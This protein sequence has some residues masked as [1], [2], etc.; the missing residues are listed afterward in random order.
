MYT[1]IGPSSCCII[2]CL[3]NSA[4]NW[5]LLSGCLPYTFRN[6]LCNI[7]L[8]V[9]K[10]KIALTVMFLNCHCYAS[11]TRFTELI[12]HRLIEKGV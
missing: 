7:I 10:R 5:W 6:V 8:N 12:L 11:A 2:Q 9:S 4:I 3:S 1:N